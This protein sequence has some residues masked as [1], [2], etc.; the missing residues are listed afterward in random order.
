MTAKG[1]RPIGF[2]AEGLRQAQSNI[3]YC[4]IRVQ[5]KDDCAGAVISVGGKK[6]P[7]DYHA[8]GSSKER[9]YVRATRDKNKWSH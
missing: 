5:K 8:L 1:Q 2:A 7:A 4:G 6:G 9:F 3:A